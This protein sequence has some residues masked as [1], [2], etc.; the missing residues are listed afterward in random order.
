M[1]TPRM[2]RIGLVGFVAGALFA[3][4]AAATFIWTATSG[5]VIEDPAALASVSAIPL[6][7]LEP[8][9]ASFLRLP[10]DWNPVI[11]HA[12]EPSALVLLG[13]GLFGIASLL[14]RR[15]RPRD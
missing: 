10:L 7:H 6:L 15:Q 3:A 13:T 8:Q 1:K 5:E 4:P 12:T 11:M 9:A 14:R 2:V